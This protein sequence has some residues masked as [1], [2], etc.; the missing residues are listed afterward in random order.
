MKI[1][2]LQGIFINQNNNFVVRQVMKGSN[3][4]P[5]FYAENANIDAEIE[6]EEKARNELQDSFGFIEG[7][8]TCADCGEVLKRENAHWAFGKWWHIKRTDCIEFKSE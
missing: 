7:K 8:T 2:K 5:D 4:H 6:A 3:M 1:L